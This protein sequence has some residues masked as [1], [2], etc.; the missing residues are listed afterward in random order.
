MVV[1]SPSGVLCTIALSTLRMILPDRV[2]GNLVRIWTPDGVTN[3]P[4]RCW[5]Q[6]TNSLSREVL[7]G[8]ACSLSPR[9]SPLENPL[10]WAQSSRRMTK[11]T[12]PSP[13]ISSTTPIAA[14]SATAEWVSIADS[15]SA[16]PT[17]CPAILRTSSA[18]PSIQKYPSAS[19]MA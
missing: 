6:I 5:T 17:R 9:H 15:I 11:T 14:A 2:F 18:R 19:F 13:L 16:V 10:D 4:M 7:E 8:A 1:T 3:L 12:T